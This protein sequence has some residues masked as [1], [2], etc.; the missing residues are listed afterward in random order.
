MEF[1]ESTLQPFYG[2]NRHGS[3][4]SFIVIFNTSSGIIANLENSGKNASLL[5]KPLFIA[6]VE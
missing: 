4:L 5:Q 3:L 2:T 1:L 6:F